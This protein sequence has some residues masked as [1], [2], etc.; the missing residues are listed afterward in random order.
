LT[1]RPHRIRAQ[2]WLV[3]VPGRAT[4]FAVRRELSAALETHLLP[5]FEA[6]F[7]AMDSGEADVHIPRLTLELKVRESGNLAAS[8]VAALKEKLPAALR[9]GMA[10]NPD[11]PGIA[12]ASEAVDRRSCLIAYLRTGRIHWSYALPDQ[13]AGVESVLVRLR[14]EALLWLAESETTGVSGML[15]SPLP[16]FASFQGAYFR[17]LQLLPEPQRS[18]YTGRL[19]RGAARTPDGKGLF[20]SD[21][22]PRRETWPESVLPLLKELATSPSLTGYLRGRIT[23]LLMLAMTDAPL[24]REELASLLRASLPVDPMIPPGNPPPSDPL[25]GILRSKVENLLSIIGSDPPERRSRTIPAGTGSR[26]EPSLTRVDR[27]LSARKASLENG[28]DGW[29]VTDAGLILL[30]PFLARFLAASGF[31]PKAGEGLP[32]G[33]L[34]RAAALLH[35]LMSGREAV[36]EFEI[37]LIKVLLGLRPDGHLPLAEGLLGEADR[38]EADALLEAV[39]AHWGAL[40]KTGVAGLRTTFLQRRGILRR[41]ERGWELR[42]EPASFDVLLGRLPWGFGIVKLPWMA[43]P[44]FTEWPS[45]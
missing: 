15:P 23:A 16:D 28:A 7:D 19:S 27:D 36:H 45:P 37:T 5:A 14:E 3:R 21:S 12:P 26:L 18:E 22:A 34:P 31:A 13:A 35:W 10:A 42:V 40:G 43:E 30:H 11:R 32:A 25:P 17:F 2:R 9:E 20:E 8:L 33:D 41:T 38:A 4:A 39:I 1:I 24:P 44:V 29:P 6:A